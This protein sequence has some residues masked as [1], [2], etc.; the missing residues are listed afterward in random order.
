M[1]NTKKNNYNSED[2]LEKRDSIDKDKPLSIDKTFTTD[3]IGEEKR[4]SV[5]AAFTTDSLELKESPTLQKEKIDESNNDELIKPELIYKS[6]KS[7]FKVGKIN[8]FEEIFNAIENGFTKN[9]TRTEY[10]FPHPR[11]WLGPRFMA[12]W[13]LPIILIQKARALLSSSNPIRPYS[14]ADY[15]V[16]KSETIYTSTKRALEST[17]GIRFF[18]ARFLTIWVL[19]LAITGIFMEFLFVSPLTGSQPFG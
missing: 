1:A 6:N 16:R 2:N 18:G 11:Y 15:S 12:V 7:S 8:T 5:D 19:P 4:L 17:G 13:A 3:S 10:A 9:K 14:K